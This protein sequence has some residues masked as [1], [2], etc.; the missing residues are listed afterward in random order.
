MEFF[1]N[2]QKCLNMLL[3]TTAHA[4]MTQSASYDHAK[5]NRVFS[6]P[7]ILPSLTIKTKDKFYYFFYLIRQFPA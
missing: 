1:S 2:T 4:F 7:P 5:I 3:Q 6:Q